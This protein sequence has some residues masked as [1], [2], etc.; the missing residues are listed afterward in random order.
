MNKQ[1]DET[2]SVTVTQNKIIAHAP[3]SVK[4]EK[5]RSRL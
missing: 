5:L 2:V 3:A 4:D 1:L